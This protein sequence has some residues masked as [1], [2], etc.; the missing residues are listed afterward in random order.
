[1]MMKYRNLGFSSNLCILA[2]RFA[3]RSVIF[4]LDEYNLAKHLVD[5]LQSL[6]APAAYVLF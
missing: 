3:L 5:M 2:I 6:R 1:M 4:W